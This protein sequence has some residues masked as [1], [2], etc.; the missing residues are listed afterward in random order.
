M[1]FNRLQHFTHS[2][3]SLHILIL[4]M[5]S[6][7]WHGLILSE[8]HDANVAAA[9]D[10]ASSP[11]SPGVGEAGPLEIPQAN[12]P[13]TSFA[14]YGRRRATKACSVCRARKTRCDN[15][16]PKCGFCSAHGGHCSYG[17]EPT[18][19]TA[20]GIGLEILD[21]LASLES[22]LSQKFQ[23]LRDEYSSLV[24]R[25][26][27]VPLTTQGGA[28]RS[29]SIPVHVLEQRCAS[30]NIEDLP[31]PSEVISLAAETTVESI[32]KWP[33]F[34]SAD[35]GTGESRQVPIMQLLAHSET[36][37]SNTGRLTTRSRD[38][39]PNLDYENIMSLVRNFIQH[40]HNKNPVLDSEKLQEDAR[41]LAETGPRWDGTTCL[42][43]GGIVP[44]RI[45][46]C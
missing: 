45:R 44:R 29:G 9:G 28:I 26:G 21:R 36:T 34:A 8:I 5:D 42:V 1:D 16:R 19:A 37:R 20:D 10:L 39:L 30:Q 33:V 18:A 12:R 15:Q 24:E 38:G 41:T 40:N 3:F 11:I 6:R 43:V 17:P 46:R 13:S 22:S 4:R 25:S 35:V 23:S 2:T 31:P 7:E 27:I 32:C 14:N